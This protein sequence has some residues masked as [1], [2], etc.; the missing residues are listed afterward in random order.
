MNKGTPESRL[1]EAAGERKGDE[2]VLVF[3]GDY[4]DCG[5]KPEGVKRPGEQIEV[6]ASELRKLADQA[7]KVRK[8]REAKAKAAEE[9]AKESGKEKKETE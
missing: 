1:L 6:P 4:K 2:S 7:A 3:A 5:G 9:A 8:S